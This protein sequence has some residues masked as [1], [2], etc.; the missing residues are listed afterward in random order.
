MTRSDFIQ[1]KGKHSDPF[2]LFVVEGKGKT[3]SLITVNY[4]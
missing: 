4:F 1:M 2:I 3:V